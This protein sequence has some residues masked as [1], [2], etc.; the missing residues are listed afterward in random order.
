MGA[1]IRG[2]RPVAPAPAGPLAVAPL[3][4]GRWSDLERLF[5]PRGACGGCWCMTPRL[6]RAEYER[7]KG[8]GNRAA[9]RALVDA[10]AQPGLIGYRGGQPVAWCALGPR[11]EFG[12]LARS[13]VLAPVDDAPVWSIVCLFVDRSAR[14][15]GLSVAM[16]E[17]AAGHVR[18]RGGRIV[19][20]Y[21]VEPR[22]GEVPP[23]FAYTGLAAAFRAAGFREVARRSPTRPI[24]RRPLD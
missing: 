12:L 1:R 14:H 11:Q 20:G 24:M 6:S 15:Q 19:E 13:R 18:A 3:T 5:G 22:Q 8:E 10:G 2:R 16:L 7:G 4:P 21:P 23:V 9:L 17:A